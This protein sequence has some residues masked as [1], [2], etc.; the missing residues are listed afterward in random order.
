MSSGFI[1]KGSGVLQFRGFPSTKLQAQSEGGAFA[2]DWSLVGLWGREVGLSGRHA[3]HPLCAVLP[4]G[5]NP[6]PQVPTILLKPN[7]NDF[8]VY[9]SSLRP[10]LAT[11]T[12]SVLGK[13]SLFLLRGAMSKQ[14]V[15]V[16][17]LGAQGH[18]FERVQVQGFRWPLGIIDS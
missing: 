8:K 1:V 2:R 9:S 7:P 14:G 15:Q 10:K 18:S 16:L 12:P 17:L 3:H 11:Q 13:G 4:H 5:K 6:L